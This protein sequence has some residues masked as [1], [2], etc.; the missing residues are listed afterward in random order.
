[1]STLLLSQSDIK[2]LITMKEVVEAVD[3]TFKELATG[4][5]INPTKVNLDLSKVDQIP[6]YEANLN[7]MPAYVGWQDT[8]GLKWAG[9]FLGERKKLGL[10]YIIAM[11]LLI[12][13]KTG[14]FKAVMDGAH[15]TNLRT[16]AQAAVALKYLHDK[17]TIR[18]GL[19]GAGMQGHTSIKAIAELFEIE[20]VYVY[21]I[22]KEAS[23]KFAVNLKDVVKGTITIADTPKEAAEVD[24]IICVTHSNDKFIKDKWVKPGTILLAMGSY[25]EC[26]DDFILNAD[27]IIVDHVGQCLHRGAL[28]ELCEAGKIKQEDIYSTIGELAAGLKEIRSTQQERI[29]CIPIGTGSMDIAIGSLMLQKA[30]E[31]QVGEYFSFT[32]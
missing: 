26:S 27:K 6:P 21:D 12:N 23:H 16:G 18:I 3:Q 2:K 29:L 32:D 15:I 9:G 8:A 11:I 24:V 30:V 7:A 1:M 31:N 25:Q 19:Y 14:H 13:P 28:K 20:E 22:K 5:T 10:P 17:K 4:M